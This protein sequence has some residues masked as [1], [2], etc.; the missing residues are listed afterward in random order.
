MGLRGIKG[1][2]RVRKGEVKGAVGVER[3]VVIM[4]TE[5]ALYCAQL[6][7]AQLRNMKA[8]ALLREARL[9]EERAN[10]KIQRRRLRSSSY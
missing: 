5:R 3:G 1:A 4:R 2:Y 9:R 6:R 10:E 7:E 8:E